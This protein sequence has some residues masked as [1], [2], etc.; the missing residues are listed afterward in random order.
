MICSE[1]VMN[2]KVVQLLKIYNF[3]IGHLVIWLKLNSSNF[4]IWK[5]TSS[6]QILKPQMI[7]SE[8][9]DKYQSCMTHQY[10]QLLFWSFLHLTKCYYTLFTKRTCLMFIKLYER[11]VT[12]VNNI[13]TT[14]SDEEMTNIKVVDL[15]EWY[16]FGIHHFFSWNHFRFQ[17]LI[18][19]SHIH[20]CS[21]IHIHKLM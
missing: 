11:C 10:L 3:Y 5:M 21:L 16:N 9:N 8:K 14:L 12:F 18:R 1:K 13:I 6:N 15:D 20:K 7:C 17:N 4:E 2:T 19:S